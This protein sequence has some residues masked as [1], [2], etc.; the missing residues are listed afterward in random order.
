MYH[1]MQNLNIFYHFVAKYRI[2]LVF[3]NW[4]ICKKRDDYNDSMDVWSMTVKLRVML[5]G[6]K[7]QT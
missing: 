2:T 3:I 6:N 4:E 5:S 1:A 7:G